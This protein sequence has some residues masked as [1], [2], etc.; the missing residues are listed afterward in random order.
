MTASSSIEQRIGQLRRESALLADRIVFYL[1]LAH[2]PVVMLLVPIG[3]GTHAFVVGASLVAGLV[4]VAG[5]LLLRGTPYFSLLAAAL[6]M[7]FSAIMIQAQLGRIEMH[8]HVFAAIPL[9]LIY[10]R[11]LPLLVAAAVI[12]VH[13]LLFTALQLN[14]V[15]L[16]NMPVIIYNYG[17]S[18]PIAFVH[19][20]FVVLETGILAYYAVFMEREERTSL[21]V[22]AAVSE[23]EATRDL[24]I[25]LPGADRDPVA[26][27]VNDLIGRFADLARET[28]AAARR[29][30]AVAGEVTASAHGLRAHFDDQHSQ[31]EQAAT[32]V[33]QMSQTI[34]EVARN[35]QAA[36]GATS[37]A[38]AQAR[39]GS[40]LVDGVVRSAH[41]LN[42][43]MQTASDSMEK[44]AASAAQI[45]SVVD[46]IRDISEQTNLLALNAAIEAARAGESGRGFAV[47]ADEV[48]CLAERTKEST[49]AIQ[50]IIEVLQS[51]TGNAV[52]LIDEGRD[53]TCR[54]SEEVNRAGE[55]LAR[56]AGAVDE[57]DEMNTQI[58]TAAEEQ[59]AVSESIAQNIV[60]ISDLSHRVV[61]AVE[62][63]RALVQ[64]LNDLAKG[65]EQVVGSYRV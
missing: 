52:T 15:A 42:D 59:G 26:R 51:D 56:I 60:T 2:L 21:G 62:D 12:A 14:E 11:W 49:A 53:L 9:L 48:R 19:A 30:D 27:A 25:A 24:A 39:E 17:C 43:R 4:S 10:R 34:V 36:A 61:S 44:L 37:G 29:I 31:T 46:V 23:F 13:H 47:V 28:G 3:Y 32:A 33:T 22:M 45:G 6:F 55:A 64:S 5:Y 35:A 57:V 40:Q 20:A 41:A 54:V 50:N 7:M 1:L 65:L 58:A 18:W 63:N 38:N 16:G 8:F